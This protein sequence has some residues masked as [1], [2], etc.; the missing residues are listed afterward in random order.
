MRNVE[1]DRIKIGI[2]VNPTERA[3]QLRLAAGC[4]I[5]VVFHTGKYFNAQMLESK[6]HEQLKI[7][8]YIGEW[9]NID[10]QDAI[11]SVKECEAD[12]RKMLI[13]FEHKK[14]EEAPPCAPVPVNHN[15]TPETINHYKQISPE[16]ASAIERIDMDIQKISTDQNLSTETKEMKIRVLQRFK[17]DEETDKSEW[18]TFDSIDLTKYKRIKSG[19][20]KDRNGTMYNIHYADKK[21]KIKLLA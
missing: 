14:R 9:F 13:K 16:R 17:S 15:E 5:D 10:E 19:L 12:M 6:V 20:Y 3:H 7:Y 4:E 11:E 21:W 8:R 1:N 2:T 18:K